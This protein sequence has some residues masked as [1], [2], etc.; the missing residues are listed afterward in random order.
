MERTTL[1]AEKRE[2]LGTRAAQRM[3]SAGRVPVVLYGHQRDTVHLSV[4]L[5]ELEHLLHSGTRMVELDIGGTTEP[6]LM[7]DL[8][9]DAMGDEILH[10]D[11]ARV[12]MDEKVQ[13]TV[14]VELHGTPKGVLSG[15]TLD[16]VLQDI[17]VEC[18]A[19]DIPEHIVLEVAGLDIGDVVHVRELPAP[20]GVEFTIDG[21]APVVTIHAP[22]T[23]EVEEEEVAPVDM[24][25]EPEVIGRAAD[26]DE[27]Q[28]G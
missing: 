12:S 8:Q 13:V 2:E 22:V 25:A 1:Q 20:E 19:S 26:E 28:E 7:K 23:I 5:K 9:Y 17:E 6:A 10:L 11:L 3:R 24:Q 15:G 4:D 18:L 14:P 27:E 21:D 16:F